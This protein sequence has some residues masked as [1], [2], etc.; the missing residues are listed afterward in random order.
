MISQPLRNHLGEQFNVWARSS[1]YN[2][3][4]IEIGMMK[5]IPPYTTE[6][7]GQ[8]TNHPSQ[9]FDAVLEWKLVPKGDVVQLNNPVGLASFSHEMAQQLMEQLWNAGVRP[10]AATGSIGQLG[11]VQHHLEDMRKMNDKLLAKVLSL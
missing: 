11:A 6:V 10:Q 9:Y 8:L 5:H 3:N 7:D 1:I 2:P 4:S